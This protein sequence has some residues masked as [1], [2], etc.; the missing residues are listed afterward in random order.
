MALKSST[1]LSPFFTFCVAVEEEGTSRCHRPPLAAAAADSAQGRRAADA[2]KSP[3]SPNGRI[4]CHLYI[5]SGAGRRYRSYWVMVGWGGVGAGGEGCR[6][7]GERGIAGC[8]VI[9]VM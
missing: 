4:C 6:T 8:S 2:V 9:E 3:C 5:V 7:L 1:A